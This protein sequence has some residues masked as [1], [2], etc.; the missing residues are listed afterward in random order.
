[1]HHA[2]APGTAEP[3]AVAEHAVLKSMV[4][5]DAEPVMALEIVKPVKGEDIITDI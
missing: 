5:I 2:T 3:V 4:L 1:M